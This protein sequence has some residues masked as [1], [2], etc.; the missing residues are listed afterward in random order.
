MVERVRL[1]FPGGGRKP[2]VV[3]ASLCVVGGTIRVC[4]VPAEHTGQTGPQEQY[5]SVEVCI[6]RNISLGG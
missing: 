2:I 4:P 3:F 6:C 1:E 5:H